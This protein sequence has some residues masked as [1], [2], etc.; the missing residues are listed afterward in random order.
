MGVA[1]RPPAV[2]SG[3]LALG[4]GW[5]PQGQRGSV[6]PEGP[7][8]EP[9]SWLVLES[10]GPGTDCAPGHPHLQLGPWA[11]GRHRPTMLTST[12]HCLPRALTTR[13]SMGRRQA[14]Q[15]G[16]PILS[17]QGRQ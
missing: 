2:H 11:R 7:C 4:T 17:W 10:A 14:P 1:A 13:P 12:C 15:M 6:Q 5:S 8:W 9:V 3:L 16:T